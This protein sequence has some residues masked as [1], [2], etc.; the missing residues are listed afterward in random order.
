M[1]ERGSGIYFAFQDAKNRSAA[2]QGCVSSNACG[3]VLACVG[4]PEAIDVPLDV[5]ER[6]PVICPFDLHSGNEQVVTTE[7]VV[8]PFRRVR[9]EMEVLDDVSNTSALK[10]LQNSKFEIRT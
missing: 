2:V 8:H 9:I 10:V 5:G 1:C 6:I 4:I 7:S 3:K